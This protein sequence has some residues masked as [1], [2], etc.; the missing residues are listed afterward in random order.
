MV[1]RRRT[2]KD[3]EEASSPN[4]EEEE[5][6]SP[7]KRRRAAAKR[8]ATPAKKR[9]KKIKEP[10]EVAVAVPP[11]PP[12]DVQPY[13]DQFVISFW[14]LNGIRAISK[15]T[16]G[17]GST[18]LIRFVAQQ[19]PDILC[20]NETKIHSTQ[21]SD[22]ADVLDGY[23]GIFVCSQKKGYAG[24][25]TYVKKGVKV[26]YESAGLGIGDH[27]TEGR[28]Q[29]LLVESTKVP[30]PFY[31]VNTYVVNAGQGLVRLS[32][33]VDSFNKDLFAYLNRL[34]Q[35]HPVVWSGDLN[36]AHE[37]IDIWNSKGNQ[38][39]AGHTPQER[40]S[41]GDFLKQ[42]Q[43]TDVFRHL[44]PTRVQYTYWSTR[45]PAN[46]ELD[47]GWRLDYFV[48]SDKLVSYCRDVLTYKSVRG[49]DHCPIVLLLGGSGPAAET[50]KEPEAAPVE[51][52]VA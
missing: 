14:N 36:V 12:V 30:T 22:F 13:P 40:Q 37:E 10:E 42:G 33:K 18:A 26:T 43:W 27:D 24:V 17:N 7:V 15:R 9:E 1:R 20:L 51:K 29:T 46:Y 16:D 49:S 50:R 31:V 23:T 41:F 4:E 19:Q 52:E 2:H 28:V 48:S 21:A 25:A 44:Y 8:K 35:K 47:R 3:E 39:S 32:Y 6:E 34:K 5:E 11:P 45:H 38:K